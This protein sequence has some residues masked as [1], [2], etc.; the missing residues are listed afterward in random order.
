[1]ASN[2]KYPLS[3]WLKLAIAILTALAGALTEAKTD[4]MATLLNF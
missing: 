1:M 2:K 3:F 4:I